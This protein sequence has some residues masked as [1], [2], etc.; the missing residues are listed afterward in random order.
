M[1]DSADTPPDDLVQGGAWGSVR[2]AVDAK[3]SMPARDFIESLKDK[4]RAKLS[5]LFERMADAGRIWNR[6][7]FK[8]VEGDIF[9]FKRF[10]IRVGC[11]QEGSTWFLTHGFRKKRDKWQ[12]RELERA[13]R[14][15]NEHLARQERER[16]NEPD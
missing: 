13:N 15:R 7:Q 11:F 5:V 3:G 6:E 1:S 12:K 2:Y 4:E 9:E 16:K 8:K 14:I 10:Q